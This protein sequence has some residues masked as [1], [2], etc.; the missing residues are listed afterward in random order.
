MVSRRFL[1]TYFV[2]LVYVFMRLNKKLVS[3]LLFIYGLFGFQF[4]IVG[5]LDGYTLNI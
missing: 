3:F 2:R 4:M 5:C 1:H